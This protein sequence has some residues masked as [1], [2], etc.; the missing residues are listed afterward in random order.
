M[1]V[2][3]DI[4]PFSQCTSEMVLYS[5]PAVAC[6]RVV[7]PGMETESPTTERIWPSTEGNCNKTVMVCPAAV[8]A[9]PTTKCGTE[10]AC[11]TSEIVCP[12]SERVC[13]ITTWI[14]PKQANFLPSEQPDYPRITLIL[15]GTSRAA[16]S[17]V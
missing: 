16:A 4:T 11:P 12:V 2:H 15:C 6:L 5:K 17:G 8:R 14:I 10:R 1:S 9:C 3:V 13:L 7:C